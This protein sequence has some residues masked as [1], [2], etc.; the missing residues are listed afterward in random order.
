MPA[1]SVNQELDFDTAVPETVSL[2]EHAGFP[3]DM[4]LGKADPQ[5]S[6]VKVK[7]MNSKDIR[8]T[9]ANTNVGAYKCISRGF[10][11]RYAS[12]CYED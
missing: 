9:I 5:Y 3:M 10:P 8:E 11:R 1:G 7:K 2:I 12:D 6:A 4:K